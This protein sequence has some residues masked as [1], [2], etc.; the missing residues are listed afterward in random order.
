MFSFFTPRA[1]VPRGLSVSPLLPRQLFVSAYCEQQQSPFFSKLPAEIRNEIYSYAFASG[2][3]EMLSLEAH[4]LSLLLTCQRMYNEASILAFRHHIFPLSHPAFQILLFMRNAITHLSSHHVHAIT[5]I[6]HDLRADYRDFQT[7]NIMANAIILFPS[8]NHIQM[9][10]LR[11]RLPAHDMDPIAYTFDRD[12]QEYATRKFVPRWFSKPIIGFAAGYHSYAWQTGE[13][14]EVQWPQMND[15]EYFRISEDFDPTGVRHLSPL[16]DPGAI[17]NVSGVKMC[18]CNCGNVEWVFANLVQETGRRVTVDLIYYGPEYRPLPLLDADTAL[19]IRMGPKAVFLQEN[20]PLLKLQ[21]QTCHAGEVSVQGYAYD[22]DD[23]YWEDKRRR[24]GD[25]VALCREVWQRFTNG[26]VR[27]EDSDLGSRALNQ[28]DWAR[29]AP[30]QS[31]MSAGE[32]VA[33]QTAAA[34]A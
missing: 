33:M 3:R 20:A 12:A 11:S 4:P 5:A 14:W 18:P 29:M 16:M 30:R 9:R 28:G 6:S 2:V 21:E 19:R 1:T 17:G 7:A 32:W 25:W 10:M 8:L 24:N 31:Q 22:P 34:K 27:S 23:D 15:D 26:S 13:R